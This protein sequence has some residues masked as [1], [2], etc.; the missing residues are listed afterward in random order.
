MDLKFWLPVHG[1]HGAIGTD[2]D[3]LTSLPA[4]VARYTLTARGATNFLIWSDLSSLG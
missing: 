4:Q 2:F 1:E 3:G